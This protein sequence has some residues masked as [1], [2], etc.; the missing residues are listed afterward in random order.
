MCFGD[1]SLAINFNETHE[2]DQLTYNYR[3]FYKYAAPEQVDST[4][5]P[6]LDV[7]KLSDVFFI[8]A[9]L[10]FLLTGVPPFQTEQQALNGSFDR[11]MSH[12]LLKLN[13]GLR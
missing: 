6:S 13:S 4:V 8:G 7:A 12:W 5:K 10:Y 2:N 1:F 9:T 3:Q 11:G